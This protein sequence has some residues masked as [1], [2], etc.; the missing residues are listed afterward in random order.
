MIKKNKNIL[1]TVI[2]LAGVSLATV[3]FATWVV[4]LQKESEDLTVETIVD[5]TLNKSVYLEAGI[6]NKKL[7]LAEETPTTKAGDNIVYATENASDSE[8]KVDANALKFSFDKLQY[9]I[10]SGLTA[11]ETPKQMKIEFVAVDAVNDINTANLVNTADC[12]MDTSYR[13]ALT[14]ASGKS[15]F[16]YLEFATVTIN[17]TT[18][19]ETIIKKVPSSATTYK[20][21]EIVNKEYKFTWGTYFNKQSP[22]TFYNEKAAVKVKGLNDAEKKEALFKDSELASYELQQMSKAFAGKKLT[23]KVSLVK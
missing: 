18:T 7:V 10:G 16:T 12:K 8:V 2:A 14:E 11:D 22:A 1:A 4:G 6:T 3:G 15:Q 21:Y 20:T 13:A 17:L 9:S 5:N 23:L 19:D